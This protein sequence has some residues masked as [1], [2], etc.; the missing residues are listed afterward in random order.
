VF[1]SVLGFGQGNF[2]EDKMQELAKHGNGNFAY[3]DSIDEGRR[4]LVEQMGATLITI[5]KDVKI[6]VHFNPKKV[7]S[8]RLIGFENRM[9]EAQDFRDDKKD[10]GEI[11]SGHSVTAFYE[12]APPGADKDGDA[13]TAP[14]SDFI[15]AA[16]IVESDLLMNLKVSYKQPDADQSSELSFPIADDN[17][18]WNGASAD[19]KFASAV[20]AFGMVLRESPYKG[21]ANLASVLTWARDANTALALSKAATLEEFKDQPDYRA[22]FIELVEQAKAISGRE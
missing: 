17:G 9:L 12:I 19:F 13:Q 4:V 3:I 21:D 11:G 15:G 20:A 14:Q 16:P 5:A 6:Q 2:K 8:Y 7:G 10:A 18:T 22:E 1:L